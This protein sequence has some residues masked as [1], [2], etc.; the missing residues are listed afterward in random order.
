MPDMIR[1]FAGK[2]GHGES[3]NGNVFYRRCGKESF[4]SAVGRFPLD[5]VRTFPSDSVR[6]SSHAPVRRVA[7][8][9]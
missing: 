8:S 1:Q 3:V 6:T 2:P 4:P 5:S 7:R 9:A